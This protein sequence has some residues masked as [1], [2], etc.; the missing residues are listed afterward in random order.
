AIV[1]GE[2]KLE[3]AAHGSAI[4]GT[5]P[6]LAGGFEAPVDLRQLAAFLENESG[7]R[8]LSL[9][10]NE[11][12]KHGAHTLEHREISTAAEGVLAGSYD[13]ALDGS[14]RGNFINERAQFLDHARVDDVH[15]A[16]G[17][18]P[19]DQRNAVGINIK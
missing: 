13:R 12:G 4:E 1:T 10:T 8:F 2:R 11:I 6:W 16:L 9:C 15:R 7:R 3:T 14:I 18:I 5:D 17:H 19:G